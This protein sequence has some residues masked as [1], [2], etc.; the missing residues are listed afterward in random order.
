MD[1]KLYSNYKG[2]IKHNKNKAIIEVSNMILAILV[3]I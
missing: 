3:T 2:K 1:G